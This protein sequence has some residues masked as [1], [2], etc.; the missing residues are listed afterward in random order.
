MVMRP[1]GTKSDLFYNT[2]NESRLEG[3]ARETADG[4]LVFVESVN[5]TSKGSL[6]SISY[7][8]PL[9]FEN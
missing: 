4:K 8:R 1:D 2:S 9:A 6:I 3:P 5:G 7:N